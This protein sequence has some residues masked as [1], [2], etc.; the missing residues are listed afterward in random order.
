MNLHHDTARCACSF[1]HRLVL[2]CFE[3]WCFAEDLFT[4]FV[5]IILVNFIMKHVECIIEMHL[6]Y[7]ENSS[8]I[9]SSTNSA[10]ICI[11]Y[12]NK[13]QKQLDLDSS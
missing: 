8:V 2:A 3:E 4:F 5:I 1:F 9:I 7:L 13:Q 6:V 12:N 11:N 10:V